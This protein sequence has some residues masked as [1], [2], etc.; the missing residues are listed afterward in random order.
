LILSQGLSSIYFAANI[1]CR[2]RNWLQLLENKVTT[3]TIQLLFTIEKD[4]ALN[5]KGGNE[6]NT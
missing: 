5:A 3:I 4:K 2:Q 1:I 6:T